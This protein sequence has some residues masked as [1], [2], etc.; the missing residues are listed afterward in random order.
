[1]YLV[2]KKSYYKLYYHAYVTKMLASFASS[3]LIETKQKQCYVDAANKILSIRH[4]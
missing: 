1:M 4:T 2:Y 3:N